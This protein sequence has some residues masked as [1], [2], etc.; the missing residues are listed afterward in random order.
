MGKHHES[1]EFYGAV[2]FVEKSFHY[3]ATGSTE[4]V[5]GCR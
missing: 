4:P 5:I 2:K 3:S 1:R